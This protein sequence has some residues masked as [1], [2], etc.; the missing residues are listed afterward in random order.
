MRHSLLEEISQ[1]GKVDIGALKSH[2]LEHFF[3]SIRDVSRGDD[4]ADHFVN[5]CFETNE[6]KRV[7]SSRV[8]LEAEQEKTSSECLLKYIQVVWRLYSFFREKG[9]FFD[10]HLFKL[11]IVDGN[12]IM[13]ELEAFGI[14]ADIL[15]CGKM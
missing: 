14:I 7:S 8:F 4:S 2:H 6:I 11:A 13:T 5:R 12:D 3:G 1:K 15:S 10:L 9:K